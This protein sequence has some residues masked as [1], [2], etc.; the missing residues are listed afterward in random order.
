MSWEAGRCDNADSLPVRICSLLERHYAEGVLLEF[1]RDL[2]V[3]ACG[4]EA[5]L[6]QIAKNSRISESAVVPPRRGLR[7]AGGTSA[8]PAGSFSRRTTTT[9]D[10]PGWGNGHPGRRKA[11]DFGRARGGGGDARLAIRLTI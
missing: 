3:V 1:C 7:P 11:S 6:S 5:P 8:Q 10:C 4:H 2:V 9:P